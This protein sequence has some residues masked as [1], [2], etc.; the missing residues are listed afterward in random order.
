[1]GRHNRVPNSFFIAAGV[2]EILQQGYYIVMKHSK[3]ISERAEEIR[4]RYLYRNLILRGSAT[5]SPES[6]RGLV[7]PD[8][9]YHLYAHVPVK[10]KV[11]G[12]HSA[13]AH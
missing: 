2:A 10:R 3:N 5:V 9:A 13:V 11:K 8:C 6:A 4:L 1:M 12:R 7:G